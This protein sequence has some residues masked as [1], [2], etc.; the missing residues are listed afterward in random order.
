LSVVSSPLA[1]RQGSWAFLYAAIVLTA[2][3]ALI[4][5]ISFTRIFS[6]VFYYHFAFL[7]VSVALF[8][9]GA[10]GVIAYYFAERGKALYRRLGLLSLAD[11]AAVAGALAVA[12][13]AG[14]WQA[15]FP[16]YATVYFVTAVPFV[17]S[18][19]IL[20]LVIAETVERVDRIYFF[21][22]LGAAAGCLLVLPFLNLMGGPGAILGA[23]VLLAAAA[24]VWFGLAGAWAGRA[25]A[26]T[27]AL[28]LVGLIVANRSLRL[29][30][31]TA[32]KGR[33]LGRELF[34]QWNSFSRVSLM[35]AGSGEPVILIDA[36]S[37]SRIPTFDPLALSPEER[38]RL[39]LEGPGYA[40]RLR[41][42][43]RTLVIGAGGGWDVARALASGSRDVT[44]VEI[45]PI[46]ADTIMLGRFRELSR[47]LFLRPGVRV[48]VEDGRSYVR[49]A[50]GRFDLI[51][52]T[53]VDT[54][55]STAAGAYA[56]SENSIYT[57]E[58]LADCLARLNPGGLLS[59]TRW[60]F[61][62][63][64]ESLRLAAL[65]RSALELRG[66][67]E[68]WRHIMVLREQNGSGREAAALDTILVSREPFPV[69]EL[70]R[71]ALE[72]ARAQLEIVYMPGLAADGPFAMLLASADPGPFY[73]SYPY[74]VRPVTDDRPF[75][76]FFSRLDRMF[77]GAGQPRGADPSAPAARTLF[78][79]LAVSLLAVGVMLALPPMLPGARLEPARGVHVFLLYFVFLGAGYVLV[80]VGLIQ[81]LVILLGHPTYA[82][83]VVIFA[84]LLFSGLGSFASRRLISGQEDRLATALAAAAA[85]IAAAAFLAGPF[86]GAGARWTLPVKMLAAA[87]YIA[88]PA[89]VM[90]MAFPSGLLRL[91]RWQPAAVK[92]AWSVNAA[93]SVLGSCAAVFLSI[94]AGLRNT[95]LAGAL[96]YAGAL[97]VV[98]AMR[99]RL[100]SAW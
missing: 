79:L 47:G 28:A 40:F 19:I 78:A 2:A 48:V 70:E 100:R 99:G 96:M 97:V 5:E 62:P 13:R 61:D 6:V 30:D 33:D 42:G 89:F 36:D 34:V 95:L 65:A 25:V 43:G 17:F 37:S 92:W 52:A 93:A 35:R 14:G 74:D 10:G 22:L 82:L 51:V 20:S 94:S 67:K 64:R 54:R 88:P 91:S 49:R 63:P 18:G 81:R 46:I 68:A 41:P 69:E 73:N 26:A 7:A 12:V 76:F 87:M 45:N 16:T 11:A 15:G 80:Q 86:I 23:A 24:A 50:A 38:E 66:Q 72:A 75:F 53:L 29:V 3:A 39:L 32:A 8:G 77:G 71:A 60:G 90:G 21:D 44:A 57:V 85:L 55:A 1:G 9:L 27:V 98:L 4:T 59:F 84:M 83:T 56:L 31:V 58:A